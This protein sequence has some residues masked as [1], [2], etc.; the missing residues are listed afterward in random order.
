MLMPSP[1]ST[2]SPYPYPSRCLCFRVQPC[3]PLA[4]M[5]LV[6]PNA[7]HRCGRGGLSWVRDR[8]PTDDGGP[9]VSGA[10]RL[11]VVCWAVQLRSEDR[12]RLAW[13]GLDWVGLGWVGSAR[14]EV[15]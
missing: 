7:T 14:L 1:S 12:V 15:G 5:L 6:S 8:A 3:T 2:S 10:S 11:E 4:S 13:A 9:F